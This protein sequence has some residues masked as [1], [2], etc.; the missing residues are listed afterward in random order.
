[1]ARVLGFGGVFFTCRDVDV[2]RAWY[3]D[4]LGFT[5]N[6]Y[7]G[8]DFGHRDVA[9]R[10]GEG[11]R[12]IW[13]PFKDDSDYFG[14]ASPF[15]VNLIVDDLDGVLDRAIEAGAREDK[16]R[17]SYDYGKFGWLKD[18]DGR[19]VELWEPGKPPSST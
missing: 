7:G 15:M 9:E 2:T 11:G 4:I 1:M 18:P 16:P 8:A 6:E 14:S 5:L 12:M 10:F 17:E 13:A 19:R 3:R